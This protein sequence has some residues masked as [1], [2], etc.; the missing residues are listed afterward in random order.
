VWA[1]KI[2]ADANSYGLSEII[3]QQI[4]CRSGSHNV[5]PMLTV[6]GRIV[7]EMLSAWN[8]VVMTTVHLKTTF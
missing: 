6:D 8:G 2:H 5:M 4:C 3:P 1:Q 7:K